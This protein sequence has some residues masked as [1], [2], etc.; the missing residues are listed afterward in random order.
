MTPVR[1]N[2]HGTSPLAAAGRLIHSTWV[3]VLVEVVVDVTV[4]VSGFVVWVVSADV[5]GVD[6]SEV[7]PAGADV[8]VWFS[9]GVL[10][11]VVVVGVVVAGLEVSVV[12]PVVGAVLVSVGVSV[13]AG[14]EVG[15]DLPKQT[16]LRRA[17]QPQQA[18]PSREWVK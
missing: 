4:L 1:A 12:V 10:G 8:D 13:A 7:C 17:N 11:V 16:S 5:C 15:T 2:G 14:S 9:V 18:T 3:L 6:G